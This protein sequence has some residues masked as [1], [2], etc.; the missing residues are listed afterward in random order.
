MIRNVVSL[1]FLFE[2]SQI[3]Q[4]L[5]QDILFETPAAI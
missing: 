5:N 1:R 2:L 4:Q 3:H